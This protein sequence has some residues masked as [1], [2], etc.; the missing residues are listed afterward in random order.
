MRHASPPWQATLGAALL[1]S[2]SRPLQGLPAFLDGC[3]GV[4]PGTP[5][6]PARVV[7]TAA[8]S[9]F[10]AEAAGA[11]SSAGRGS[12]GACSAFELMYQLSRYSAAASQAP[13]IQLD[14]RPAGSG[15]AAL[16]KPAPPAAALRTAGP[17][18]QLFVRW[19]ATADEW[20]M[21]EQASG[22]LPSARCSCGFAGLGLLY[23]PHLAEAH[24]AVLGDA[25]DG[26]A[27]AAPPLLDAAAL[28]AACSQVRLL[29][30]CPPF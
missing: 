16:Q 10:A 28:E 26:A 24:R 9:P 12:G 21:F 29:P 27:A 11:S 23:C 14:P 3:A 18:S 20:C 15:A 22:Q 30:A 1:G 25:G 7:T 6:L 17:A 4:V 19:G 2:S 13:A 8:A 5:S